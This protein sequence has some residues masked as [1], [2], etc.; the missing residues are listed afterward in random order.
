MI[1]NHNWGVLARYFCGFSRDR[2]I[3]EELEVRGGGSF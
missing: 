3:E 1:E 2:C